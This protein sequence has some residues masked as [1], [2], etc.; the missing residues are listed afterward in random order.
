MVIYSDPRQSLFNGLKFIKN[1]KSNES[2]HTDIMGMY[3]RERA[4]C[5]ILVVTLTKIIAF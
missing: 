1:M 5:R 4:S 2:W 3:F